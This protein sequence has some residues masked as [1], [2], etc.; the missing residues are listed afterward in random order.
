M[1]MLLDEQL[2]I[3]WVNKAFFETFVLGAEI[4]G[5]ALDDVWPGR[6]THHELWNALEETASGG[7]P[8]SEHWVSHAFG[9]ESSTPM[10][11][12]AR[13]IP[14][15]GDRPSLTLVEMEE[16]SRGHAS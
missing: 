1:L 12:S 8:F 4:L 2:R 11:F 14:A 16:S 9:R 13:C 3:I 15:E 6:S 5:R 10:R 7:R